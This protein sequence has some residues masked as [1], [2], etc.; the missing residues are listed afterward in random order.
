MKKH[1]REMAENL[2]TVCTTPIYVIS[3]NNAMVAFKNKSKNN[4]CMG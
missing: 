2:E 4:L 3:Q 1:N